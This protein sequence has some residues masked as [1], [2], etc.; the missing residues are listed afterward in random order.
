MSSFLPMMSRKNQSHYCKL[1]ACKIFILFSLNHHK[2]SDD[3]L[4]AKSFWQ[5]MYE[6]LRR[7]IFSAW[8]LSLHCLK[9][10]TQYDNIVL[11][12][13]CLEFLS[14]FIPFFL[15]VAAIPRW[16]GI[17]F[18]TDWKWRKRKIAV[19][20]SNILK[21]PETWRHIELLLRPQ[22]RTKFHVCE[23]S[24]QFYWYNGGLQT[25]FWK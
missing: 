17:I 14:S 10:D 24:L 21:L 1:P 23:T 16:R 12:F 20:K 18:W 6:P 25:T 11:F 5:Y 15:Q 22:V 7:T 3:D 8:I 4:L 13:D 19:S 2:L 9:S